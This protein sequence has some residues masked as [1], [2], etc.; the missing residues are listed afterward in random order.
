[1]FIV[2]NGRYFGSLL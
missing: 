1:M 2:S